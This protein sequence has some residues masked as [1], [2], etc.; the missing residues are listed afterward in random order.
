MTGKILVDVSKKIDK[1][2]QLENK[3][4]KPH[5]YRIQDKVLVRN[6]KL[7]KYEES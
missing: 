6:K 3:N 1:I 5:T 2:N 4:L 7:N